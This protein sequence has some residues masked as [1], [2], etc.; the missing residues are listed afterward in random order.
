MKKKDVR[1]KC[2]TLL[3]RLSKVPVSNACL[4]INPTNSC[5]FLKYSKTALI[6]TLVIRI[7]NYP[8]R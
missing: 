8:D 6:R 4:E 7:A 2:V 3:L 5:Y 1:L